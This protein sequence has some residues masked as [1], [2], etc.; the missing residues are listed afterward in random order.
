VLYEDFHKKSIKIGIFVYFSC[1]LRYIMFLCKDILQWDEY[2]KWVRFYLHFCG[3]Y[4]HNPADLKSLPLFTEKLASKNQTE[5]QR[6]QAV[7]AV[8]FYRVLL[9]PDVRCLQTGMQKV[10]AVSETQGGFKPA[11]SFA[12]KANNDNKVAYQSDKNTNSWIS[13]P[14]KG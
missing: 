8:E 6:A 14:I 9:S 11:S 13:S 2:K 5:G 7:M 1:L 4:Q 3:K 10:P 12:V